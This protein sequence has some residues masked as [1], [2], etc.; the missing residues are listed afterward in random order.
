MLRKFPASN[1]LRCNFWK[2]LFFLQL[3]KGYKMTKF[4]LFS[5]FKSLFFQLL[6]LESG[7][8][9]VAYLM[10]A[11]LA[12][13][14]I[15]VYCQVS[16][17]YQYLV[18]LLSKCW[19]TGGHTIH[20]PIKGLL[21]PTGIKPIPFRNSASKVTGLQGTCHYQENDVYCLC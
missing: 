8:L 3:F 7:F 17:R 21:P 4:Q 10:V 5:Y 13:L 1:P 12:H 20:P 14:G 18:R 9:S 6:Y 19:I 2:H 16:V 11:N 15:S